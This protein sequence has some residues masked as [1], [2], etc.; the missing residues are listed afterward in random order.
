[1]SKTTHVQMSGAYEMMFIPFSQKKEEKKMDLTATQPR[2]SKAC[3]N[4][5]HFILSKIKTNKNSK[6]SDDSHP[7]A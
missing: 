2:K 6:C 3:S 7:S 4:S 1:M 5:I